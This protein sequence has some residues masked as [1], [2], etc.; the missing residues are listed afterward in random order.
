MKKLLAIILSAVLLVGCSGNSTNVDKQSN[1][2]TYNGITKTT[3]TITTNGKTETEIVYTDEDGKELSQEEGE[4]AFEKAKNDVEKVD[5]ESIIA[6]ISFANTTDVDMNE[7]YFPLAAD[8]D[9]GDN[10]LGDDPLESGKIVTFKEALSYVPGETEFKFAFVTADGD[11]IE[12]DSFTI[13]DLS[14]AADVTIN[15][16]SEKDKFSISFE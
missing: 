14:D 8:D 13:E 1:V 2:E 9:W 15:I 12:F 11:R 7:M 10:I 16:S 3:T 5:T 4:A 6:N